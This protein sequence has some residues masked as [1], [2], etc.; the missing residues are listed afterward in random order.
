MSKRYFYGRVSA[1]D[2][3]LARQLEVA[4]AYK[5]IDRVFVDKQSGKDFNRDDYQEMKGLVVAGDEVI[6]PSLDRLGRNKEMIK[7][8]LAWFKEHGV[9]VRILDVPTTLIEYPEGQEWIMEM[10]N[11]ILIEVLGSFAEQEREKIL[12][13]QA[14]GIAAMPVDEKG[15]KIST[16]PGKEGRT[17]GR[18]EKRPVNFEEVLR[19]QRAG[20][21]TLKEALAE[22]KIGRTRW[23]ELAREMAG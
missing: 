16:K 19:R 1:K 9:I 23:Y 7:I 5:D 8:E 17:Y 15:R 3:N 20:E 13:R 18:K 14:D 22:V 12:S 11:N 10:V 21:I 4:K 2:Q 6:T